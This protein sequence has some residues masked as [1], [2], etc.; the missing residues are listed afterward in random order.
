MFAGI[1][2]EAPPLK[3]ATLSR[4]IQISLRRRNPVTEHIADFNK[5]DAEL[6]SLELA[7]AVK[8]WSLQTS[9]EMLRKARPEMPP[10]LTDRQR[11]AWLPLVV[12]ADLISESWGQAARQWAVELSRAIPVIPDAMVQI[13]RDVYQVLADYDGTRITSRVLADFRNGLQDRQFDGDLNAIEVGKRLARFGIHPT[14][15]NVSGGKK[16]TQERGFVFR[17]SNGKFT[18]EFRDAFERYGITG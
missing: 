6:E 14:K 5:N 8:R 7:S 4:C 18:P 12:I 2:G 3:G 17:R 9:R 1:Y 10:Q 16:G 11:D 13:L 15:W